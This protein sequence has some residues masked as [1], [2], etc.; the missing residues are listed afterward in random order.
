MSVVREAIEQEDRRALRFGRMVERLGVDVAALA[1]DGR[2]GALRAAIE[3]C[4]GCRS[5][6]ECEAYLAGEPRGDAPAFCPN[7]GLFAR[8]ERAE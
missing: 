8:F 4:R 7:Q 2:G 6:A 1:A 3:R 5:T